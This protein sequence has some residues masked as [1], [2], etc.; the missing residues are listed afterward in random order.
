MSDQTFVKLWLSG[1][2]E[3]RRKMALSQIIVSGA[4]KDARG[5]F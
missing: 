5:S 4:V 2:M 1:D 3:A